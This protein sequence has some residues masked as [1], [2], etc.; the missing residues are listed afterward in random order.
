MSRRSLLLGVCGVA[1]DLLRCS[2]VECSSFSSVS[3][4]PNDSAAGFAAN[5]AAVPMPKRGDDPPVFA[6]E[7]LIVRSPA[8]R[9]GV[10]NDGEDFGR[11]RPAPSGLASGGDGEVAPAGI[12]AAEPGRCIIALSRR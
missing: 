5:A 6:T 12:V 3:G 2:C 4:S 7:A 1:H 11:G 10:P 8:V 9:L